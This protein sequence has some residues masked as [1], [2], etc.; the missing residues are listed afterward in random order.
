MKLL[1]DLIGAVFLILSGLFLLL[2]YIC[3]RTKVDNW[4][5]A[6]CIFLFLF[7]LGVGAIAL[8]IRRIIL[9]L[10][11]TTNKGNKK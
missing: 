5:I 9:L 6:F 3:L 10:K 8:G 1:L 7:G 4:F 11:R 2:L